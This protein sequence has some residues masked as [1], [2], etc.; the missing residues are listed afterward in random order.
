LLFRGSEITF[1]NRDNIH[2]LASA[3]RIVVSKVKKHRNDYIATIYK[4]LEEIGQSKGFDIQFADSIKDVSISKDNSIVFVTLTPASIVNTFLQQQQLDSFI[5]KNKTNLIVQ[6]TGFFTR[7][8]K[9]PQLLIADT[10]ENLPA[11]KTISYSN[12]FLLTY[13]LSAK[14]AIADKGFT[15][16]VHVVPFFA[17]ALFKP[18]TW[19]MKQQ[20]KI[21]YTEG[22]EYFFIPDHFESMEALLKLL[23]AFSGFKKW[24]QSSM[25]LVI[26]GKLFVPPQ[27][28][29]EKFNT[30]KYREDVMIYNKLPEEDKARL[31]AG[32]YAC[33]HLPK[34]DNDLLPLLQ[35]VQC[36][37]PVITFETSSIKEYASDAILTALTDNYDDITQQMI[38]LYK[39]EN[40]RN[41]LVENCAL[42]AAEFSKEKAMQ[43]LESLL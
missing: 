16:I 21:D 35:S 42:R 6:N 36:H 13:S 4:L 33:I 14:Q 10:I 37:T 25:K 2:F 41:R 3:M 30:Y 34:N 8:K 11:V 19:S 26:T 5:K 40:L 15:N 22:R 43:T 29:E 18:I 20:V 38:L 27:D 9:I 23:K 31:L 39:D 32:A 28:W 17:E 12:I 24:Q 7:Q 1:Q